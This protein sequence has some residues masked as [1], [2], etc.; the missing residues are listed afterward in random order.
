AGVGLRVSGPLAA[1]VPTG[2]QNLALRAARQLLDLAGVPVAIEVW[3]DKRVPLAAGLGGGSA[4]AAA[5]LR[6]GA[7]LLAQQGTVISAEAVA[8]R[9]LTVG[10]DVPA[11]LAGGARR[12][13][14]RGELLDAVDVP[15]LHVIVAVAAASDTAASYAGLRAGEIGTSGRVE[16]ALEL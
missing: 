10:S 7:V 9:A 13:R 8:E 1:H 12:V 2:E 15:P 4:D 5:V 14:G 3:L 6:A 11:L 16:R